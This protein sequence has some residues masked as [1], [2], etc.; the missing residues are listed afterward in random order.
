MKL[1]DILLEDEDFYIPDYVRKI[2]SDC[3]PFFKL[4]EDLLRS[5][6]TIW[7]VSE[8]DRDQDLTKVPHRTREKI[9]GNSWRTFFYRKFKPS[10]LPFR[11]EMFSCQGGQPSNDLRGTE[12]ALFPIGGKYK[13]VYHPDVQDFNSPRHMDTRVSNHFNLV[14]AIRTDLNL[15]IVPKRVKDPSK[16]DSERFQEIRDEI[17]ENLDILYKRYRV[18]RAG[19]DEARKYNFDRYN[20]LWKFLINNRDYYEE[21]LERTYQA[22]DDMKTYWKEYFSGV[23]ETKSLSKDMSNREVSVYA[24]DGVYYFRTNPRKFRMTDTKI[25]FPDKLSKEKR[26]E[27]FF[28]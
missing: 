16:V 8:K 17:G 5:G 15:G 28:T 26:K 24:P 18:A 13:M 7:R 25:F 6:F 1:K 4:N 11:N 12:Y 9:R 20:Q 19:S 23:V 14:H 2:K 27:V 10:N 21:F 3:R 22:V